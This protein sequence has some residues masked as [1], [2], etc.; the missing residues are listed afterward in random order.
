MLDTLLRHKFTHF[1]HCKSERRS[2][3]KERKKEAWFSFVLLTPNTAHLVHNGMLP[4]L[5]GD[6]LTFLFF[7]YYDGFYPV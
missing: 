2:F 7:F 3:F 6:E 4:L 5:S 1:K